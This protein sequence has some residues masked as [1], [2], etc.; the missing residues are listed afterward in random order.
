MNI[1]RWQ[2]VSR[3]H[4][5]P[6]DVAWI[7]GTRLLVE[8]GMTG[9]TGNVYFGLHEVPDMAFMVHFL[10]PSELLADIG[11][12]IGSYALLAAGISGA[13]V[14][15]FEPHPITAGH[16]ERNVDHNRL[17]NQIEVRRM[18][19]SDTAGEG[20]LTDEL[21]TMNHLVTGDEG[22]TKVLLRT[23]DGE[24][25]EA[26]ATMLKIDVE[27]HEEQVLA[28][29]C[30]VLANPSLMAIEI[31][32]VTPAVEAQILANGFAEAFYDPF[33]RLLMDEPLGLSPA[34]RL[35]VRDLAAARSR[36]LEAA[37]IVVSGLSL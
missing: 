16:L 4:Q 22:G 26:G 1:A 13:R 19:L 25:G 20:A 36:V 7:G 30:K 23:L 32:T 5:G 37:P 15:A 35:F 12:N 11:A 2:V 18:A 27:G 33:R 29:G 8:R 28:G 34:N 21:D 3:L 31:E 9:A 14:V 24:L 10:R 6:R 17:R